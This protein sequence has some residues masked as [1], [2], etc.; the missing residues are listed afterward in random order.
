MDANPALQLTEDELA[1]ARESVRRGVRGVIPA[2][3]IILTVTGVIEGAVVAA[4]VAPGHV[5]VSA[6]LAGAVG[7][8]LGVPLA[9]SFSAI[10]SRR[11]LAI[12][13]EQAVQQRM[14]ETEVRRREFETRFGRALEMADDEADCY[15]VIRRGM[16]NAVP[17]RAVEL[18]LAD[19]SHAHLDRVVVASPD[20]AGVPG[21]PVD[22]PDRCV[23]ARRAQT[24]VFADSEDLDACPLL[25]GRDEGSC[26]GVCVPVSIM[27][28][29]VGVAHATGPQGDPLDV[30]AIEAL[31][32][33][34]NLAGNRLGML[35]IM[36][37]TQLQAATDGL[38][39]L[40]NRRSLENRARALRSDGV[41]FALVMADLDRF[42]N[43]N[44][45]H[46]HVAGDRALRV[47]AETLRHV[48]RSDDLACR[49]GGE[50]FVILLPRVG[51][52]EAIDAMERIRRE[53]AHKTGRGEAPSF[54]ASFGVA[55]SSD[56][57]DF[58][59]LVHRAD[60]AL[61]LAKDGGRDRICLDGHSIAV[62][63]SLTAVDAF[64]SSS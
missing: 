53:L 33:L 40:I 6:L 5:L 51:A 12:G 62:A 32:A 50:E 42:K 60:Q 37:E 41:E 64:T 15:D 21:C 17:D 1:G 27:G 49:Y 26:S 43:L 30:S 8:A 24:Q 46:G 63:P 38:T 4:L 61:F 54:T 36:A 31:Q 44:D 25:R 20:G 35:R 7:A 28:T 58:D 22:S 48:L 45:T 3:V 16:R 29:T 56:A 2:L 55:H 23:A 47:F 34:A 52:H 39:G 11:G 10:T 9:L 13:A 18:L 59:E 14:M 57:S 19:N